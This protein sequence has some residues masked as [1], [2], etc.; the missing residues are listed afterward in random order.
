MSQT[1]HEMPQATS[2]ERGPLSFKLFR[3]TKTNTEESP[4]DGGQGGYVRQNCALKGLEHRPG[5][6]PTVP[7]SGNSCV[8][9]DSP[10]LNR[11]VSISDLRRE[12][13]WGV[14]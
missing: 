9:L 11:M 13:A 6:V 7:L 3:K 4:G 5:C 1:N 2:K 12:C 8:V 14:G 10:I